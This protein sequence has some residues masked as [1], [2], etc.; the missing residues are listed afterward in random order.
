MLSISVRDA[1]PAKADP[2]A[3]WRAENPRD[4]SAEHGAVTIWKDR[5]WATGGFAKN[6]VNAPLEN[7]P[8]RLDIDYWNADHEGTGD[9]VQIKEASSKELSEDQYWTWRG[10]MTGQEIDDQETCRPHS[11]SPQ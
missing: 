6:E 2:P 11:P 10:V 8:D 5:G 7:L 9:T 1:D 3:Y 4:A